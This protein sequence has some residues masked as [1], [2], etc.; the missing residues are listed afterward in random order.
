MPICTL[1]AREITPAEMPVMLS[2]GRR[3]HLRCPV[4]LP[5]RS[6]TPALTISQRMEI[7]LRCFDHPVASCSHCDRKYRYE[8]LRS[9]RVGGRRVHFCPACGADL[10]AALV[11]HFGACPRPRKT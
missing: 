8:D 10:E 1:C 11:Q 7:L 5:D 3:V 2:N 6:V 9:W 4:P